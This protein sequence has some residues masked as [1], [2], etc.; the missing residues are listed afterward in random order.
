MFWHTGA[1]TGPLGWEGRKHQSLL[2]LKED[3]ETSSAPRRCSQGC[4]RSSSSPL[5]SFPS[6]GEPQTPPRLPVSVLPR[7]APKH[8]RRAQAH[9]HGQSPAPTL[10]AA[11]VGT[12][13]RISRPPGQTAS[14]W[15]FFLFL[16]SLKEAEH[17]RASRYWQS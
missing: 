9:A 6:P 11:A 17:F 8:T 3:K 15:T 13:G 4:P 14:R 10:S 7:R 16:L 2:M 12:A 1:S 5:P